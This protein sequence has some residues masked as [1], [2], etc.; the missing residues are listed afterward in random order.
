MND[1]AQ[2]RREFTVNEGP[3]RWPTYEDLLLREDAPRGS[4]W[5]VFGSGDELGTINFLTP[6]I[7]LASMS[8]VR[9]GSI[10]NLD[11]PINAFDPYP[12][13]TRSATVH[14]IF[15]TNPNHRDD[16]LDS[17]Y[18]QSTSQV[19]G[20]R[21][22]RHPEHGFYGGVPDYEVQVGSPTLGIQGWA[23]HGIVGRGVLLD[24]NRHLLSEGRPIDQDSGH[25][26]TV[27][28]LESTALAQGIEFREGDILMIRTGWAKHRLDARTS[29]AGNQIPRSLVCPGLS[30][31]EETVRWLWDHHFSMAASD[32]IGLE[33]LP[34]GRESAFRFP[35]E[36]SPE[37]GID[38]NGMIH[39]PLIA[40]LG[41]AIGEMWA[42]EDLADDCAQDGVYECLVVSKPL[43]LVGGVGSPANA[44]A[45]K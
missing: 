21:H 24:V 8:T 11:Y 16:Y 23:E 41:M 39:R 15:S 25:A 22:M 20:L 12:T 13:G 18:L 7:V 2:T 28:D 42:L 17:F 14:H 36:P 30:Q 44:L 19:D 4:S 38:H 34:P 33:A 26:F 1:R 3:S 29:G 35:T 31:A 9:R 32:N 10:F 5:G 40:L 43:N 45:V 27:S 37:R 6:E